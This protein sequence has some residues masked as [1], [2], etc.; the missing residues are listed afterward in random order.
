MHE[1]LKLC[2]NFYDL[3]EIAEKYYNKQATL[4]DKNADSD[5]KIKNAKKSLDNVVKAHWELPESSGELFTYEPFKDDERDVAFA[6]AYNANEAIRK[7]PCRQIVL[8]NEEDGYKHKEGEIESEM[9]DVPKSY[10]PKGNYRH[11]CVGGVRMIWELYDGSSCYMLFPPAGLDTTNYG[12]FF[13]SLIKY[14]KPNRFW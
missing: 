5:Y 7:Y 11:Y 10:V 8:I 2:K 14:I 13:E 4:I 1:K 12:R 6:E 3:G 9:I